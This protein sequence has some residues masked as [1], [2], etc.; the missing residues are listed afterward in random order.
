MFVPSCGSVVVTSLSQVLL[1]SPCYKVDD[2]NKLITIQV[3]PTRLIYT[4]CS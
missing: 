1:L 2:G 4:H 3:V